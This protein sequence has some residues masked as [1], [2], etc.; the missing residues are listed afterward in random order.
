MDA[1]E[2]PSDKKV[3]ACNYGEGTS[4]CSKGA[5]CYVMRSSGSNP[6]EDVEIF[7]RSRSG[8]W[9][10]KWESL[11]KLINFRF[12]TIPP[13]HPRYNDERLI[14]CAAFGAYEQSRH[15]PRGDA[16]PW[17]NKAAQRLRNE[18][19]IKKEIMELD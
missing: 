12:K 19:S 16:K 13:E 18:R 1:Q 3:I 11:H 10:V 4:T 2:S 15:H 9:I 7:A 5:L 8:R 17:L 6:G 14:A